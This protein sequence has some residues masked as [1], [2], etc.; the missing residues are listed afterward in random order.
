ML[1]VI[2]VRTLAGFF[3]TLPECPERFLGRPGGNRPSYTTVRTPDKAAP[4]YRPIGN[5]A[6]SPDLEEG[7][8]LN[9]KICRQHAARQFHR[10]HS[11]KCFLTRLSAGPT[12]Q[13]TSRTLR[14]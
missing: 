14:L 10:G 13:S 11:A 7:P 8:V 9:S 1:A 3:Y 12:L 2:W 5:S 4:S 6:L